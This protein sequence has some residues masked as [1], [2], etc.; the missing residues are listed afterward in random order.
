MLGSRV[1]I[2]QTQKSIIEP[3]DISN[4]QAW[5]DGKDTAFIK[6]AS[7]NNISADE[8]IA[9]WQDKSGNGYNMTQATSVKRPLY[10]LNAINTVPSILFTA[11]KGDELS[12]SSY[13]INTQSFTVFTVHNAF[14]GNNGP[15]LHFS[16]SSQYMVYWSIFSAASQTCYVPRSNTSSFALNNLVKTNVNCITM[17]RYNQTNTMCN[18]NI[19]STQYGNQAIVNDTYT[20]NFTFTGGLGIAKRFTYAEYFNGYIGDI[21]IYNRSLTDVEV[22][23]IIN[24]LRIKWNI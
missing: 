12:N 10:K 19:V 9:T 7:G 11:S 20:P 16:M 14:A 15:V 6:N 5:Y 13:L 4:L 21:I 22:N 1:G 18:Y 3:N 2:I 23:D 24:Y 8:A 17:I